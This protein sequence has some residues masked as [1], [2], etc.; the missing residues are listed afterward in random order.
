MNLCTRVEV[1]S[2]VTSS[3]EGENKRKYWRYLPAHQLLPR[4]IKGNPCQYFSKYI[5]Q[6]L[7]CINLTE[8]D[9]TFYNFLTKPYGLS[10]IMLTSRCELWW[11]GILQYQISSIV[12]MNKDINT[13]FSYG[14]SY[15][16]YKIFS[17][18]YKGKQLS[19]IVS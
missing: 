6:L 9:S 3:W 8:L 4:I 11:Q 19:A 15:C 10:S 14:K 7:Y 2:Q 1:Y 12:L 17:H 18:I 5:S 13:C 16:F